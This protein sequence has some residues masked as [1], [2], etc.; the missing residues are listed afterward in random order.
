MLNQAADA[1]TV[2][3]GN[4]TTQTIDGSTAGTKSFTLPAAGSTYQITVGRTSAPAGY[5]AGTTLQIG[6]DSPDTTFN[7]PR[8]V[9]VN[10]DPNSAA[11]GRVYVGNAVAGTKGD[12]LFLLNA[13]LS[14]TFGQGATPRNGGLTF[15]DANAPFRLQVGQDNNV[16]VSDIGAAT[17]GIYRVN[18]D[19]TV[20][21]LVAGGTGSA[22][23]T[24]RVYSSVIASGAI[25]TGDLTLY[26]TNSSF[27]GQ[28]NSVVQYNVGSGPLPST[29]AGTPIN[30][31]GTS[32][33][34]TIQN[35]TTDLDRAD[36]GKF[37]VLQNR[38]GGNEYGVRVYSA[39]GSTV[40]FDSLL[41][42][43][44]A[45]LDGVPDNTAPGSEAT[46]GQ[47]DV[48]V[49]ARALTLTP[50][51]KSLVV[52]TDTNTLKVLALDANGVPI[53]TSLQTLADAFP[54]ATVL[55]R[56]ISV[57][58]AGNLYAVSSGNALLRAF[59]PGGASQ[60]TLGFDGNTFSF[61]AGGP[62]VVP[63]P[64]ALALIGGAGLLALRRRR[65]A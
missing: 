34:P 57:D 23:S 47:Q 11:F 27:A 17:G 61:A 38:S 52:L 5:L 6:A 41:A 33:F 42:T 64:T 29:V 14:D 4:G 16:Y 59:D 44:A 37:F 63:E 46:I 15:A 31:T 18:P 9:A 2:T 30:A 49:Q 43:R 51:G 58:A 25:G 20:G 1:V 8:G 62:A 48:L 54:V 45:G 12:G 7:A 56:D 39:D 32:S 28:N 36:D 55:G 19:A 65:R 22:S 50:D 53:I 10:K 13:D 35:I 24:G 60:F 21:E 26:A 3:Y 40:L